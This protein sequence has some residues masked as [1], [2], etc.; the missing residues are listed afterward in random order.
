[1]LA[2]PEI[3]TS[4]PKL[5]AVIEKVSRAKRLSREDGLAL[6]RSPDLH[7]V[8]A[9]GDAVR[10][11]MHANRI[12]YVVNTHIDYTNVCVS[13]CRFCA[14]GRDLEDRDA[15]TLS[16][17][18]ACDRVPEGV[19]EI[20]VVGGVNPAL[21]LDYFI[22]LLRALGERAPGAMMKAFTAIELHALATRESLEI[23]DMLRELKDAGLGMLPGGGAEIFDPGIRSRI[24]PNKANA[25]EWLGVHRA[26]HEMGI[27]TNSTML[28]G[29]V[30]RDEHRVDHLLRLRELQDET[31]GFV[32]HV[33]LPYLR[34][35][36]ALAGVAP[37]P[38][39]ALD[40]RQIALARLMLDNFAHIKA[41]WRALGTGTAQVALRAGADDLD[42]TVSRE[43]VMHEAGSDAPRS[44]SSARMEALIS[45]AGLS[46]YR[47]DALHMPLK[48]VVR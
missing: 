34:G 17:E 37:P 8:C 5:A 3:P 47:R 28:Y 2:F 44:L 45:E 1:V 48:E 13:R 16:P 40:L 20:H 27:P 32:A 24:C 15:Y 22:D 25:E 29:H 31:G 35:G 18:E 26:A 7:A 33:P 6:E 43:E 9:L 11:R 38:N 19:D 39:G 42:G 30:E 12:G 41:Y 4:D 36:N 14:F 10:A 23:S 46:P 21:G